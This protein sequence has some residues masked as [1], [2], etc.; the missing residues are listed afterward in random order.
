MLD[1]RAKEF[2]YSS[3]IIYLQNLKGIIE[4]VQDKNEMEKIIADL[5]HKVRFEPK[6]VKINTYLEDEEARF[7]LKGVITKEIRA[8]LE[9]KKFN[10]GAESYKSLLDEKFAEFQRSLIILD[11]DRSDDKQI[12]RHKN[13]L[14]LPGAVRPENVFCNYLNTLP[15]E[16]EFW[17]SQLGGYNKQVFINNRPTNT[18]NRETMK[19]WFNSEMQYWGRGGRNLFNR[20]K[21]DNYEMANKFCEELLKKIS[22]VRS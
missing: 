1:P 15:R 2:Y 16:D 3:E 17:S 4:V 7:F 20:W 12:K 14:C 13:V 6:K 10:H 5:M 8:E 9:I 22:R 19:K 21:K 11:G 18:T